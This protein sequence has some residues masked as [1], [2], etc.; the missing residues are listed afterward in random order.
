MNRKTGATAIVPGSHAKVDEINALRKQIGGIAVRS[1]S[2][3]C[4]SFSQNRL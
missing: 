2:L 1:L 3:D 4:P